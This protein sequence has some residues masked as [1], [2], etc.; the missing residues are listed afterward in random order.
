MVRYMSAYRHHCRHSRTV[1]ATLKTS[2]LKLQPCN[3]GLLEPISIPVA[4]GNN[5]N[6][7]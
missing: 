1:S 6:V 2:G 5:L 4:T 3:Y 7:S